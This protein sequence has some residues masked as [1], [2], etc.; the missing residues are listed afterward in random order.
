MKQQVLPQTLELSMV[1]PDD[2]LSLGSRFSVSLSYHSFHSL[3]D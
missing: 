1:Y 2:V 3:T